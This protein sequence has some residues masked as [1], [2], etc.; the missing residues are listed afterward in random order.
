M[1]SFTKGGVHM[2]RVKRKEDIFYQ[3]FREYGE[4]VKAASEL[5]LRVFLEF[6][7]SKTLISGLKDHEN[8]CD[9]QAKKIFIEMG[10][11][12]ITPFDREDI[13][14]L[15]KRIDD[16]VDYMEAAASRLDLF[17]V[18]KMRP[19]AQRLAEITVHA[20]DELAKVLDRLPN[21]KK[22]TKVMEL[23]LGVDIIEDEGDVVYKT[24]LADLF[25]ENVPT[26]EIMKWSRILD[27]MELALNACEHACDIIQGVVMKNA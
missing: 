1:T 18:E 26:L 4:K 12:F 16:V 13:G 20:A 17:A 7:D 14:A 6:P 23:A 15:T 9:E 2:S 3:L 21:Y 24:A 5:Y 22:D 11:S 10:N 8:I 27:R 19:E 25:R